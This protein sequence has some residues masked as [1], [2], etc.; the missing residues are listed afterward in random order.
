MAISEAARIREAVK[1]PIVDGDGHWLEPMPV[2]LEF[3][4][5]VGGARIVDDYLALRR[6][7]SWR[8]ATVEERMAKRLRRMQPWIG[9]A[10]GAPSDTLTRATAMLPALMRERMAELGIDFAIIY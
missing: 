4:R 10:A 1:H 5:D 2:W 7:D 9:N 3:L 6:T 8:T